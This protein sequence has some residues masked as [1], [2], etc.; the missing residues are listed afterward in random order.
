[1]N[2]TKKAISDG[3]GD[4]RLSMVKGSRDSVMFWEGATE[5]GANTYLGRKRVE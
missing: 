2:S 5:V 1:M 3:V 4:E